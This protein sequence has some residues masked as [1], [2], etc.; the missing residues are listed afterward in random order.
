MAEELS[1]SD[2]SAPLTSAS[3]RPSTRKRSLVVLA[4]AAGIAVIIGLVAYALSNR[5]SSSGSVL[6]SVQLTSGAPGHAAPK[7]VSGVVTFEL[8]PS[9]VDS[10]DVHVGPSG[11]FNVSLSPGIWYA[12][13]TGSYGHDGDDS[14][15]SARVQSVMV[16]PGRTS[17]VSLSLIVF[18]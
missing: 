15:S 10:K 2:L 17:E 5:G 8:A 4:A 9:G 12:S 1:A 6:G 3:Q 7:L 18:S 16:T 11:S 13:A 14:V